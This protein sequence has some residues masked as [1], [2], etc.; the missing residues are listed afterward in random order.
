MAFCTYC[1]Q[2]IEEGTK[3]CVHC[4][5]PLTGQNPAVAQGQ[6]Q[7]AP[8]G[9]SARPVQQAPQQ[10]YQQPP[11][12]PVQTGDDNGGFGWGLLGFCIPLAGLILF[13]VWKDTKPNNGKAAGM[14]A[15]I[16][17]IISVLFY[18]V[19]IFMGIASSM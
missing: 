15:L 12:Q 2:E 17:V 5:A 3:F 8:Q 9:A 18:V 7:Q 13:L 1:G 6:P 10:Q 11:V 14:G 19:A 4:G 16:S